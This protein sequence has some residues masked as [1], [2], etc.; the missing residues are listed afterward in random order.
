LLS[1]HPI[2]ARFHR[3]HAGER[4]LIATL[5]TL[6]A[7]LCYQCRL[8]ITDTTEAPEVVRESSQRLS[9]SVTISLSREMPAFPPLSRPDQ[10]NYRHHKQGGTREGRERDLE[11]DE[12][13]DLCGVCNA[14]G[15][16]SYVL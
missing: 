5:W 8:I 10:F 7:S 2:P 12:R 9:V 1:A 4:E 3:F 14:C 16:S 13:R 15:V 11:R 6:P